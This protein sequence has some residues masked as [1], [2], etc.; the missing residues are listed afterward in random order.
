MR[1]L[2]RN[3]VDEVGGEGLDLI[4]LFER[5][6]LEEIGLLGGLGGE[7]SGAL[8]R[9]GDEVG[10]LRR[11]RRGAG[12]RLRLLRR[13]LGK[14]LGS[15]PEILQCCELRSICCALCVQFR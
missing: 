4:G 15:L 12:Q 1:E 5:G 6:G 13:L 2:R 9:L 7:L 14:A 10:E 3:G 11:G 8:G